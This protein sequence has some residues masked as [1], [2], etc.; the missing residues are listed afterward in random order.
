VN[1]I[2]TSPS[3]KITIAVIVEI[4]GNDPKLEFDTFQDKLLVEYARQ[5]KAGAILRGIRTLQDYEY[6]F[7]M[8]L[9]NRQLAPDVE[10]VFL[11]AE[12]EYS[13]LSSTLIREIIRLGGSGKGMVPPMVEKKLK[14]R[15]K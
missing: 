10:T 13:H 2:I 6:E 8:A 15:L 4:C 11:M 14:D 5:K 12:S 3:Y 7:Q 1:I 9:A